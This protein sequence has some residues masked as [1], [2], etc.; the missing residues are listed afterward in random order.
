ML[1]EMPVLLFLLKEVRGW[2]WHPKVSPMPGFPWSFIA[3]NAGKRHYHP[4]QNTLSSICKGEFRQ[5][6]G[7]RAPPKIAKHEFPGVD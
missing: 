2:G 1:I 6:R 5:G 7:G 3:C 4:K